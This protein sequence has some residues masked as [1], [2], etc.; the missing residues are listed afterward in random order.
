MT[1]ADLLKNAKA[2][3]YKLY[4]GG[5]Y[6]RIATRVRLADG[7]TIDYIDRLP[8]RVA[9]RMAPLTIERGYFDR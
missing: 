1:T 7:R 2:E 8:K 6:I 3:D 9:L 5:R 4:L